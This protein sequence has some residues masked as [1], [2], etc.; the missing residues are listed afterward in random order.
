[1]AGRVGSRAYNDDKKN[2]RSNYSSPSFW[3]VAPPYIVTC[4]SVFWL[5]FFRAL[6]PFWFIRDWDQITQG[7]LSTKVRPA[8]LSKIIDVIKLL[9]Q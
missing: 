4:Y 5:P 8:S 9:K 6:L 2:V 1:M 3:S 7:G